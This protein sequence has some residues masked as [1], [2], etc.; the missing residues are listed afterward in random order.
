MA[1]DDLSPFLNFNLIVWVYFT[2]HY[3]KT[4][5]YRLPVSRQ[6]NPI[7]TQNELIQCTP[8]CTQV[9]FWRTFVDSITL[10]DE[11][12]IGRGVPNGV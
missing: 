2:P 5:T 4:S 9:P 10:S 7:I 11:V 3:T 12:G 6:L 8:D 1:C